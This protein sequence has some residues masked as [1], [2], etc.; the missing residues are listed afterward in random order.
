MLLARSAGPFQ[1]PADAALNK[2]ALA[3]LEAEQTSRRLVRI[4]NESLK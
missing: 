4:A 3:R 2:A 1:P